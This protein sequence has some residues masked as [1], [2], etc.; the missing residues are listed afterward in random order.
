MCQLGEAPHFGRAQV[1]TWKR[2]VGR[3]ARTDG[4]RAR[5]AQRVTSSIC[6]GVWGV[7]WFSGRELFG[8]QRWLLHTASLGSLH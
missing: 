2:D 6:L 5:R 1:V 4:V 8:V 3:L 7:G